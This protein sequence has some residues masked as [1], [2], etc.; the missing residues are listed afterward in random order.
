MYGQQ[1]RVRFL[2][3]LAR[4]AGASIAFGVPRQLFEL[5][6]A[7]RVAEYHVVPRSRE[8]RSE[9]AAHQSRAQDANSHT[10]LLRLSF[11][12]AA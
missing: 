5:L 4:R 6:V 2:H 8:N 7:P 1:H 12:F 9:L 10:P 11:L 3:G